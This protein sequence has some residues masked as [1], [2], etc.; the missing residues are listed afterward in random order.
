MKKSASAYSKPADARDLREYGRVILAH[1]EQTGHAHEI[2]ASVGVLPAQ[3][4]E[5]PG[6][7]RRILMIDGPYVLRHEEHGAITLDPSAPAQVRQGDVLL[8]PIA[9]GVYHVIRQSEYHP[10]DVRQ[11]LD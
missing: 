5:E 4:F 9:N 10:E 2:V 1:G 11:V 6:T 7:G 8:Q 3:Y